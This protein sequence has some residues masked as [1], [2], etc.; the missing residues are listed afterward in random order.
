ME[1]K[2]RKQEEPLVSIIINCF[3]GEKFLREAL[4]SILSQTFS[5]WEIIFWDNQS[6]DESANIYKS[7]KD[8]R[9]RYF[10]APSHTII[11]EARNYAVNQASG[12]FIAFLD[13]DDGWSAEKLSNQI[14]LFD[15]P[16]VGFVCST[17]WA[18]EESSGLRKKS[19]KKTM[20]DGWVLKELISNYY[21]IMSSLVIRKS[22][23][24]SIMNGFDKDLHILGDMDFMIRL[25]INWK[26]GCVQK[27][28]VFL[29]IHSENISHTQ[30]KL[31]AR[32][33]KLV[34]DKFQNN[35]KINQLNEFDLLKYQ[36][37]YIEGRQQVAQ[38][39][40][41]E[42]LKS[43]SK[44]PLGFLKIKLLIILILG[45]KFLKKIGLS[46]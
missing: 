25:A 3:N 35:E 10:Y 30:R 37:I 32:E 28:L 9:F 21:L 4:D 19:H 29:R 5:N 43:I 36:L 12:D 39:H 6:L 17:G 27:E 2:P 41:K 46:Q 42:A 40:W 44:L 45:R 15:D 23:F 26:L 33:L 24:E 8:H 22:A 34:V 1:N 31:H 14:P 7:Y 11:Y 20:P 38:K 18:L 16:D 13:V